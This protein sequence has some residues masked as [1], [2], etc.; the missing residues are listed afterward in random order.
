MM[1]TA[2]EWARECRPL[3]HGGRDALIVEVVSLAR[4]EAAE[5]MRERC[6]GVISEF[7]APDKMLI[8]LDQFVRSLPLPGDE[9][10]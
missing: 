2:E 10:P 1:R 3:R 4:L 9:K 8:K 6:L 7:A 5:E